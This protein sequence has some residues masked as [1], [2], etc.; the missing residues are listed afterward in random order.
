MHEAPELSEM[1]L[2]R[3]TRKAEAMTCVETKGGLSGLRTW[4][5]DVL[6]FIEGSNVELMLEQLVDIPVKECVGGKDEIGLRDLAKAC[7]S[8]GPLED[9][10]VQ[11]GREFLRLALPIVNDT[12]GSNDEGRQ[13]LLR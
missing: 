9:K 1:V 13:P 6:S 3:R 12:G 8:L 11:V 2:H 7:L 4:V 10:N 5:F